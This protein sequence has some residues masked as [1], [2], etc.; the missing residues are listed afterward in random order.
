MHRQRAVV[1]MVFMTTITIQILSRIRFDR[2]RTSSMNAIANDSHLISTPTELES[3]PC[4]P[5]PQEHGEH[6][7]QGVPAN[8]PLS[9]TVTDDSNFLNVESQGYHWNSDSHRPPVTNSTASPPEYDDT[10]PDYLPS[11]FDRIQSDDNEEYILWNTPQVPSALSPT[12]GYPL[13]PPTSTSSSGVTGAATAAGVAGSVGASTGSTARPTTAS[14]VFTARSPSSSIAQKYPN[15]GPSSERMLAMRRWSVGDAFKGKDKDQAEGESSQ[16]STDTMSSKAADSNPTI[17]PA[18]DNHSIATP[19]SAPRTDT[20]TQRPVDSA[21]PEPRRAATMSAP[22]SVS[23]PAQRTIMAAIVEKLVEKLTNEI[24][25]TF[26][27][28]F[29]LIYRLFIT[30]MDLLKLLIARFQWA[31]TINTPQRQIVRVRTFVT[32]RHWLLNYFTHDFMPS[33]ALRQTF[34]RNLIKLKEHPLVMDSTRDQRIIKELGRYTQ[35]L[36][37]LHYRAMAHQQLNRRIHQRRQ[38]RRERRNMT[39]TQIA[40][41]VEWSDVVESGIDSQKHHSSSN[42]SSSIAYGVLTRKSMVSE[43][44]TEE[45]TV[46]FRSSDQSD[47]S[48]EDDSALDDSS[49]D[50]FDPSSENSQYEDD[51]YESQYIV[52]GDEQE[53][54]SSG[55]DDDDENEDDYMQGDETHPQAPYSSNPSECHLPSPAFSPR[56][57]KSPQAPSGSL[58]SHQPVAS[59]VSSMASRSQPKG[60]RPGIP[61]FQDTVEQSPLASPEHFSQSYRHSMVSR[62]AS[63]AKTYPRPLSTFLPPSGSSMGGL[64]M[65]THGSMRSIEP[66]MNPPPRS[67]ASSEKKKTWSKLSATVGRVKRA[68]SS[69]KGHR[70]THSSTSSHSHGSGIKGNSSSMASHRGLV[71]NWGNQSDP[72]GEKVSHYLLGSCTG[73]NMLASSSEDHRLSLERKYTGDRDLHRGNPGS[74]SS[75]EDEYS[76]YEMVQHNNRQVLPHHYYDQDDQG[77]DHPQYQQYVEDEQPEAPLSLEN[78]HDI[79]MDHGLPGDERMED[80]ACSECEREQYFT[81]PATLQQNGSVSDDEHELEGKPAGAQGED[82]AANKTEDGKGENADEQPEDGNGDYDD[83]QR[84]NAQGSM[85]VAAM[86]TRRVPNLRRTN[87]RKDRANRASWMT[88][89]STSSSNFGA[90]LSEDHLSPGQVIRQHNRV[91]NADRFVERLFQNQQAMSASPSATLEEHNHHHHQPSEPPQ[92]RRKSVD[93]SSLASRTRASWTLW[94]VTSAGPKTNDSI[95]S[96]NNDVNIAADK[97]GTFRA[98]STYNPKRQTAPIVFLHHHFHHHLT[99]DKPLRR[100]SSDV[101][102]LEGWQGFSR[103]K[104]A[105]D[106][107]TRPF[108]TRPNAEMQPP[109]TIQGAAAVQVNTTC[110]TDPQGDLVDSKEGQTESPFHNLRRASHGHTQSQ[111]FVTQPAPRPNMA[112]TRSN[113]HPHLLYLSDPESRA[114][115][116]NPA[117]NSPDQARSRHSQKCT[118]QQRPLDQSSQGTK[119]QRPGLGSASTSYTGRPYS[120]YRLH[121]PQHPLELPNYPQAIPGNIPPRS[122]RP[123]PLVLRF[124]SELIAQQLCLIER[125]MLSQ[126]QWYELVEAGSKKKARAAAAAAAGKQGV[127]ESNPEAKAGDDAVN[128]VHEQKESIGEGFVQ[129]ALPMDPTTPRSDG[130]ATPTGLMAQ[131]NKTLNSQSTRRSKKTDDSDGIKRLVDRFNM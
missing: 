94:S 13:T 10:I 17:N 9:N 41:P 122:V 81:G 93:L 52:S 115:S 19:T 51:D 22:L 54:Y 20:P 107:T 92:P 100:H 3:Q 99:D 33:K 101:Q 14:S 88:F 34:T 119:P 72:E 90:I 39:P 109:M 116:L 60:T 77:L 21:P 65:S 124:R 117:S 127:T 69:S 89:S 98:V 118:H 102:N 106:N 37:K 48:N 97:N 8:H 5:N 27:T 78:A 76:H 83:E 31:L 66:Y 70:H 18:R 111:P 87:L 38:Q 86:G 105:A 64:Q 45:L 121:Q 128:A 58:R 15:N 11:I 113:S 123:P 130:T 91:G 55:D 40:S 67:V 24:D 104:A 35:S 108:V 28:D 16:T 46:E 114:H 131:A 59:L 2:S 36:K 110:V 75:S 6:G 30:P 26:L 63:H 126:V 62:R 25:Y 12:L 23:E 49:D 82:D 57:P 1:I 53:A 43:A 129:Q 80:D 56:S 112:Q 95:S 96:G 120:S 84:E 79:H 61:D 47:D 44:T 71:R 32:L 68:F 85:D 103:S 7:E 125:E 50:G 29:F 73:M 4:L 74:V 42:R